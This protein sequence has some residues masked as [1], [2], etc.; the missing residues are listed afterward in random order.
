MVWCGRVGLDRGR[1][2]QDVCPQAGEISGGSL[3]LGA[4]EP[5]EWQFVCA[6]L[7][8]FWPHRNF[9][10]SFWGEFKAAIEPGVCICVEGVASRKCHLCLEAALQKHHLVVLQF[11]CKMILLISVKRPPLVC[12]NDPR[13][14][15]YQ[16]KFYMRDFHLLWFITPLMACIHDPKSA[17]MVFEKQVR[18]LIAYSFGT[19]VMVRK[20]SWIQ[21]WNSIHFNYIGTKLCTEIGVLISGACICTASGLNY[22]LNCCPEIWIR[23]KC[24]PEICIRTNWCP[25]LVSWYQEHTFV[26]HWDKM[27]S[28]IGVLISGAHI[29]DRLVIF[30]FEGVAL[31]VVADEDQVHRWGPGAWSCG[32]PCPSHG[33]HCGWILPFFVVKP[34]NRWACTLSESQIKVPA[35][36]ASLS[37]LHHVPQCVKRLKM[38]KPL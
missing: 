13:V 26:L 25:E 18:H 5:W 12:F 4:C 30:T 17:C 35:I 23:T 15:W 28:W 21:E 20:V 36:R 32:R 27:M 2:T 14:G 16:I 11:P 24:C 1:R 8:H 19:S 33:T 38:R 37:S 7:P 9:A 34:R 3:E 29:Q 6:P 10:W 22:V 31:H